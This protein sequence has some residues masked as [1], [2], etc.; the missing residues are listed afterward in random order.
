MRRLQQLT[1]ATRARALFGPSPTTPR[2]R[3]WPRPGGSCRCT[4]VW[5]LLVPHTCARAV[6]A[7][8]VARPT[9]GQLETRTRYQEGVQAD[10]LGRKTGG[11]L[12]GKILPGRAR[13]DP[14]RPR[15]RQGLTPGKVSHPARSPLRQDPLCAAGKP[16]LPAGSPLAARPDIWTRKTRIWTA[17][18]KPVHP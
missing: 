7:M 11:H 2:A 17:W 14:A 18:Q 5:V 1:P 12:P 6:V 8:P 9:K 15:A 16:E 3:V 13:E 4:K 10:D